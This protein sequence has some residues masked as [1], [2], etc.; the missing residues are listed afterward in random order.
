MTHS[1][2]L[3]PCLPEGKQEILKVRKQL[4]R[5]FFTLTGVPSPPA[6]PP[7]STPPPLLGYSAPGS[8]SITGL[9]PASLASGPSHAAKA[10]QNSPL[11]DVRAQTGSLARV[12]PA[13]AK[14]RLHSQ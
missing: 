4:G 3:Q 12:C 9:R 10:K 11:D 13:E 1:P 7:L 8:V 2:P 5:T 14:A 6:L